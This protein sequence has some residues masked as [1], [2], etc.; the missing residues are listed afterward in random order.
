MIRVL[1]ITTTV[2]ALPAFALA[3]E[4]TNFAGFVDILLDLLRAIVPILFGLA[5]VWILWAGS[6]MILHA[7]NPQK[8]AEGRRTLMWGIIVLF[9]MV[10][11]W[12]LVNVLRETFLL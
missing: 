5:L 3:Q 4:P 11:M 7:D 2:F 8:L 6:Q 9:I 1:A 12:G 10:S